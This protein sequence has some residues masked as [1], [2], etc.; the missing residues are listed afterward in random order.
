MQIPTPEQILDRIE[1]H[2][3]TLALQIRHYGFISQEQL[4]K[5]EKIDRFIKVLIRT[6]NG[7]LICAVQ[8]ALHYIKIIDATPFPKSGSDYVRDISFPC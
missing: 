6:N 1:Q 4:P 5:I 2:D 7:R 8:D 3:L